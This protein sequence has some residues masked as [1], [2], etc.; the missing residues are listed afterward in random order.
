MIVGQPGVGKS[1]LVR[2]LVADLGDD[3]RVAVG[4]C[5][6][7]GDGVTYWPLAE[8]T[9]GLTGG[10]ERERVSRLLGGGERA[11]AAASTLL[12]AGG[13]AGSAA[14]AQEVQW[15]FRL[16]LEAISRRRPLVAVFDDVHWADPA[17]LDLIEYLAGYAGAAR[18]LLVCL[19][20]PDLLDRRP[21]LATVF[22]R[23]GVVRVEPLSAAES[24]RLLR[25]LVA[26]RRLQLGREE[27][28]ARAEGNPLFLKHYVALRADD[29]AGRPPPTIQA[30][31]AARIDALPADARQ[32][33]GAASVEGRGFHRGALEALVGADSDVDAALEELTRRELIRPG[34]SGFP[35]D[36][37]LPVRAHPRPRRLLRASGQAGAKRS[38]R[39]LCELAGNP[40]PD[41]A[42][43]GR[44]RRLP[45]R[46]GVSLPG[47][48]GA[49]ALGRSPRPARP[50]RVGAAAGRRPTGGA[51][52]RPVAGVAPA[53][54]GRRAAAG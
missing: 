13:G 39:A 38:A 37:G 21:A 24:A 25:G 16:L 32:V 31:L 22:G 8:M 41:W 34:R 35:G 10:L 40:R 49:S 6:P 45:P 51:R 20:R 18:V 50:T 3:A 23:G 48:A 12:T 2:E 19:A 30:L 29:P 9:R 7:Y 47:R 43:A 54:A 44:D 53:A 14:T 26:R 52:R 46:A 5:L 11:E 33:A 28:L 42:G 4:R 17:M 15:A 36:R 27:I 1:R